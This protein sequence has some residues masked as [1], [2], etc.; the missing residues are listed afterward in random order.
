MTP[1]TS[2][3]ITW[4]TMTTHRFRLGVYAE[5]RGSHEWTPLN[6]WATDADLT[7]ALRALPA[8]RREAVLRQLGPEVWI[9]GLQARLKDQLRASEATVAGLT[10][11]RD[12]YRHGLKHQ[13]WV[14]AGWTDAAEHMRKL[15]QDIAALQLESEMRRRFMLDALPAPQPPQAAGSEPEKPAATGGVEDPVPLSRITEAAE[16][17]SSCRNLIEAAVARRHA[18]LVE[19]RNRLRVKVARQRKELRR[20]NRVTAEGAVFLRDIRNLYGLQGATVECVLGTV[21]TW[22]R[23]PWN[24]EGAA[25]IQKLQGHLHDAMGDG[26]ELRRQLRAAE[27]RAAAAEG[28]RDEAV[29]RADQ[30]DHAVERIHEAVWSGNNRPGKDNYCAWL[31][32]SVEHVV[33]D[34]KDLRAQLAE[35]EKSLNTATDQINALCS[36]VW[37]ELPSGTINPEAAVIEIRARADRLAA[38][39]GDEWR[40][41]GHPELDGEEALVM[42]TLWGRVHIAVWRNDAWREPGWGGRV[43][44]VRAWRPLPSPYDPTKL[45]LLPGGE[46]GK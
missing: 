6:G 46:E 44:D 4:T 10:T 2:E 25:E 8:E 11:E 5:Q 18:G 34:R 33:K 30:Y 45:G 24:A 19:E 3:A 38:V 13:E 32:E 16:A 36:A 22:G 43:Y 1:A 9:D 15:H 20:L 12:A 37:P 29:K 31:A 42:S 17:L 21:R 39:E 28:E 40:T 41:D 26:R 35:A 14:M 23:Q 7:E 27:S